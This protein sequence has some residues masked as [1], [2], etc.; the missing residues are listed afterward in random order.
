MEGFQLSYREIKNNIILYIWGCDY[1]IIF[2]FRYKNLKKLLKNVLI[3]KMFWF[4]FW[5]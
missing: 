5:I 1:K 4:K 3:F 2:Y